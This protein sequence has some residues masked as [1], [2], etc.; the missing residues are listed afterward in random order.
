MG[1][2]Q[3]RVLL[4]DNV[5][6]CQGIGLGYNKHWSGALKSHNLIPALPLIHWA[7]QDKASIPWGHTVSEPRA[8]APPVLLAESPSPL[9]GQHNEAISFL[10]SFLC[11]EIL[12]EQP[13]FGA[14]HL[15]FIYF[16]VI[17]LLL[18]VKDMAL[19]K[20]SYLQ[21]NTD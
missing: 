16:L 1:G 13:D 3:H 7:T 14:F 4:N 11:T 2:V 6:G 15:L 9:Q 8:A 21:S 20:A 12:Q 19:E 5:S 10:L 17:P 18:H